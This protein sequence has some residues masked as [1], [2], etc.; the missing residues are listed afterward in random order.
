L[1]ESL[2]GSGKTL[3]GGLLTKISRA[4]IEYEASGPVTAKW[5]CHSDAGQVLDLPETFTFTQSAV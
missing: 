1:G 2:F 5:L 3:S 4:E